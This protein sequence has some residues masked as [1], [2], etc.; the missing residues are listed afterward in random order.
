MPESGGERKADYSA[1]I[2]FLERRDDGV[3]GPAT[4][5]PGI[6]SKQPV[7]QK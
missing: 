4:R 6:D 3:D 1:A 2:S 7:K 5:G